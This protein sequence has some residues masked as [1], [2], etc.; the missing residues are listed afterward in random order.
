MD[1]RGACPKAA[2]PVIPG[3]FIQTPAQSPIGCQKLLAS[4]PLKPKS[5]W[6]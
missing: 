4:R 5:G 1:N 3:S 6:N 2:C